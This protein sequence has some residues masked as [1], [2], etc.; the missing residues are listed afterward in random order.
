MSVEHASTRI[1]EAYARGATGLPDDEVWAVEAHLEVCPVC[2]DRLSAAV[3]TGVP[4]VASLVDTVWSGLE[5][6][7]AVATTPP[8]RRR[9]AWLSRWATPAMVPWLAMA[10]AVTLAA[11]LLDLLGGSPRPGSGEVSPVLVLAPV[12]P[13]LGVAASWARGLDPAYELTASVPR[14]GLQLVLRRTVAVLAVV[15]PALLVGGWATGVTVALWLL[16]CLAF[17]SATLALGG[18]IGVTRAAV[19]LVVVWAA[20]IVA[21]TLAE[22][23]T[24]VALRTDGLP[25]WGLILALGLGVVIA[26]R[27][28]Y[29]VLGAHR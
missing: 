19:S 2:R 23:R 1:I 29:S 27:G 13:V 25:V 17:T 18:V 20:V 14:A 4:A 26:R 15:V 24:T 8:R 5:P 16:P 11:L 3:T 28:A 22:G 21:P 7:V 6:Q 12:L 10:A 9:P